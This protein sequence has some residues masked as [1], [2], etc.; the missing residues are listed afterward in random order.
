MAAIPASRFCR[1]ACCTIHLVYKSVQLPVK[2]R[3]RTAR[4]ASVFLINGGFALVVPPLSYSALAGSSH[5][6]FCFSSFC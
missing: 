3:I 5:S 2:F 1:S 6:Y 4:L